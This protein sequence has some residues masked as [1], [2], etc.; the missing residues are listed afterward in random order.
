MLTS[1]TFLGNL[2]KLRFEHTV[3]GE[4]LRLILFLADIS[5]MQ[6]DFNYWVIF[7]T[8]L[9]CISMWLPVMQHQ[10]NILA[11]SALGAFCAVATLSHFSGAYLHY[12][13]INVI[14]RAVDPE[15][16]TAIIDPPIQALG[17]T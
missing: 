7:A 12:I 17:K 2:L 1:V 14:R 4:F 8:L 16:S 15:F 9:L 5:L 10:A 11:C 13:V 6:D 3:V